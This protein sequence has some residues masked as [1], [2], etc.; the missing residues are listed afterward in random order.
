MPSFNH[1]LRA[2]PCLLKAFPDDPVLYSISSTESAISVLEYEV[3][4]SSNQHLLPLLV[5]SISIDRQLHPTPVGH[6]RL[7]PLLPPLSHLN[8]SEI[9]ICVDLKRLEKFLRRKMV[10]FGQ[11]IR[12]IKWEEISSV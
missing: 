3:P 12:F 11:G 8:E 6:F 5:I 4:M 1:G 7:S 10:Y 9:G 2:D